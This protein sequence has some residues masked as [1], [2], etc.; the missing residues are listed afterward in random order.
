M[1]EMTWFNQ[2]QHWHVSCLD[3][4]T[5]ESML[6]LFTKDD[7]PRNCYYGDGSVIEDSV[8]DH[9]LETYRKLESS[10]LWQKGDVL[11]VDN[12]LTAHGRNPFVGERKHMVAM[13]EMLSYGDVDC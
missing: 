7:L 6:S 3:P 13:G 8:M 2:A 1:N 12:L 10:F 9:I 11:M 4:A 5:R